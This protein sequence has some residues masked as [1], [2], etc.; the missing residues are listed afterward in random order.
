MPFRAIDRRP[1][2]QG[3]R[4]RPFPIAV[5][6][7]QAGIQLDLDFGKKSKMDF[8]LRG[9]DDREEINVG[10]RFSAPPDVDQKGGWALAHHSST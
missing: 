8:R 2:G 5:I 9:N 1:A 4:T 3:E 7:A 10:L 6:P